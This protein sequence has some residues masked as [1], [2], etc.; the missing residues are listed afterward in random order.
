WIRA[1]LAREGLAAA[2]GEV[3]LQCF[4]RLLGYVFT[5]VSF[6]FC[7][8]RAGAT[9]AILA[10]VN[11]TFGER[12]AYLL[13]HA[14]GRP[15]RDGDA[16]GARKLFHVSPFFPVAGEYRF[17]FRAANGR[18]IARIDY[19]DAAGPLLLTSLSGRAQ[20]LTSGALAAA[21]ARL[22]EFMERSRA[23][24]ESVISALL[25]PVVLL[26]VACLSILIIL[27]F[28]VPR[29]SEMFADAGR[30]LPWFTQVV[31]STGGFVQQFWWLLAV[32]VVGAWLYMRNQYANPAGRL[33]WD[34]RWLALPLVG[35]VISKLEAARFTRTLGTLVA[36]GVPLL[37]AIA[38]AREVIAN[39]VIS[40]AVGGVAERVR[41]GEGL[42]RPLTE[43]G[44]FPP[45]AGHLMQVGE[46]TGNLEAMLMK[47]ADI[48]EREVQGSL[49][50]LM[51][52]LEPA[53]IL[54]LALVIAAIIM[55][56]VMAVLSINDLAL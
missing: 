24:R 33:R 25:Y 22:A 28:V 23:L 16:L 51:T 49:R 15:I 27:G 30:A 40:E 41:Q 48:Y 8:D 44:V 55:S 43:T 32:A 12:H 46:E 37:D 21:L 52:V 35:D 56:I 2:V 13:A 18:R 36:N 11:N 50:R 39:R 1:L 4:P 14:D 38:I 10:E 45:L 17:R 42:A 7:E 53:L 31:V 6:W 3:W 26:V 54:G 9:R 20:P 47:L 29:V 19:A 34:R 5:P